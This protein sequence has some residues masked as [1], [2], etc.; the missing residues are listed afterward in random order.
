LVLFGRR[1]P[2]RVDSLVMPASENLHN[3]GLMLCNIIGAT[4]NWI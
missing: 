3:S 1:P 2:Q 4:N